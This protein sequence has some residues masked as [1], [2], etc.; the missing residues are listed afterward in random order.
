[1]DILIKK[2]YRSNKNKA[3]ELLKDKNGKPYWKTAVLHEHE[4]IDIWSTAFDYEGE[5]GWTSNWEE[6]MRL[7][8]QNYTFKENEYNGKKQFLINK[9]RE[10][11]YMKDVVDDL[12]KR[13]ETLENLI[14]KDGSQ[15]SD[16]PDGESEDN[17]PF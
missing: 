7:T 9:K 14:K 10:Q 8:D 12:V 3:G 13:V 15:S 17:L 1:M 16:D 5:N 11:D 2:I 4:G 6:G